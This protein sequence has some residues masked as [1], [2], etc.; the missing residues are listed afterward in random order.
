MRATA[1]LTGAILTA[2]VLA[3]VAPAAVPAAAAETPWVM[4]GRR[5]LGRVQQLT[6]APDSG[7]PGADV[8]S[9]LVDAPASRVYATALDVI[10]RNPAVKVLG[11]DPAHFRLELAEGDRHATL[12]VTDLGDR[13]SQLV[14][15]GT[16]MPGEPPASSRVVAAVLKVCREMH[17]QC[18]V[19]G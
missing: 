18:S 14:I 5:A 7:Q 12:G 17:K 4:L 9:V 15:A 1:M 8:A 2:A 10:H 11:Q 19:G 6:Q 16:T 3:I 13:L